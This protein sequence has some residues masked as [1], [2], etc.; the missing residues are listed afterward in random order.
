MWRFPGWGS[1]WSC[2]WWPTPW[3]Q[4]CRIWCY[5][6]TYTTA[7]GNAGSLTH[8]LRPGI[9]PSSSWVLVR[10]I[11]HWAMTG[12][13]RVWNF[14]LKLIDIKWESSKN[15]L[16]LYKEIMRWAKNFVWMAKCFFGNYIDNLL[17]LVGFFVCFFLFFL[18]LH[19]RHI[20]IPRLWAELE[21]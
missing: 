13:P 1:N 10:F 9:E 11:N 12:T 15:Y 5:S 18:W 14:C 3:P 21:L 20:E 8:W 17:I 6:A 19:L 16:N 7:H 2:N 4:Q